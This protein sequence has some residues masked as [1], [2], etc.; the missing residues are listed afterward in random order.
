MR[1]FFVSFMGLHNI[2]L[3]LRVKKNFSI[4]LKMYLSILRVSSLIHGVLASN[5]YSWSI[6]ISASHLHDEYHNLM[7]NGVLLFRFSGIVIFSHTSFRDLRG[8]WKFTEIWGCILI[9][10]WDLWANILE[11]LSLLRASIAGRYGQA[12]HSKM[13]CTNLSF[14]RFRSS[15]VYVWVI[16]FPALPNPIQ[17]GQHTS[18]HG[19]LRPVRCNSLLHG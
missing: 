19:Q 8:L 3:E 11:I 13:A 12:D 9:V 14:F 6:P 16:G 17:C 5:C 4:T 1:L 7:F 18:G 2:S 10:K 15:F